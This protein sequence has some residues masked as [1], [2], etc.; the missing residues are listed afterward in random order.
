MRGL[1]ISLNVM[2]EVTFR[3]QTRHFL[4]FPTGPT[5]LLL[6]LIQCKHTYKF[7]NLLGPLNESDWNF[8]ISFPDKN[9]NKYKQKNSPNSE[10]A[11]HHTINKPNQ[12]TCSLKASYHKIPNIN[13]GLIKVCKIFWR[14]YI[15]GTYI[16]RVFWG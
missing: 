16:C 14:A 1:V 3:R 10:N 11:N 9:L 15:W 2:Q 7:F 5:V 6:S 8:V 12:V 13:S 4:A